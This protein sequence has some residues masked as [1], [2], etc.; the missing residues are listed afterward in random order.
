[1]CAEKEP[2]DCHRTLL[3]GRA[4][5]ERGVKVEHILADGGLET[6]ADTMDRL[7]ARYD[8][9]PEGDLFRRRQ[10]RDELIAEAIARQAGRA[11]HAIDRIPGGAGSA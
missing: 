10:P 7:L 4:L 1:M 8:I 6:H 11:G 3:V 5:D 2:L 9:E